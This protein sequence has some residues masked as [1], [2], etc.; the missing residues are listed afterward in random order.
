[1]P[2]WAFWNLECVLCDRVPPFAGFCYRSCC[3][4]DNIN[5]HSRALSAFRRSKTAVDDAET[6]TAALAFA[7]CDTATRCD[8]TEETTDTWSVTVTFVVGTHPGTSSGKPSKT[9]CPFTSSHTR[10]DLAS[11]FLISFQSTEGSRTSKPL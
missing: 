1:M 3:T 9:G 2:G 7:H 5:R 6:F 4:C 11:L 8:V 10:F